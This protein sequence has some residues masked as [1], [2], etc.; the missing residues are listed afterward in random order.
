ME[1]LT[2]EK[3]LQDLDQFL[4]LCTSVG[5]HERVE[6]G[7]F[8]QYRRE[9]VKL[10]DAIKAR[11]LSETD[12]EQLNK[13]LVALMEGAEVSFLLPYLQQSDPTAVAPKLKVCLSGPMMPNDE[14]FNS[15]QAR[16][17]Q[18]EILIARTLW[19]AGFQP[20]LGE[21]PDLKCQ[22]AS[23]WFFFECKRLFSPSL[24]QLRRR[25]GQAAEQVQKSRSTALPGARGIIA[26]SLSRILNPTQAAR[27]CLNEQHGRKE[28]AMWLEGKANEVRDAW[29]H[30]S[31]KKIVGILFYAASAFEDFEADRYTFGRFSLGISLAPEGSPDDI[32]VGKLAEAM[33]ATQY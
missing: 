5:L 25:I 32:A 8:A 7:R 1:R 3:I 13:Y 26:I 10:I 18:F 30:L 24:Q 29:E 2:Y 16:N 9:I 11:S 21:H 15:N 17:I 4:R 22:V 12:G 14:D 33:E 28:L 19:R 23:R 31:H 20:I 6:E 27:Q